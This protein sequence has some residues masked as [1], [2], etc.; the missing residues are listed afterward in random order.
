M[1]ETR[2]ISRDDKFDEFLNLIHRD[3]LTMVQAALGQAVE[4]ISPYSIHYR[5]NE[6]D[7]TLRVVSAEGQLIPEPRRPPVR[8]VGT[9]RERRRAEAGGE[10][11]R[12]LTTRLTNTLES[13]TDAFFHLGPRLALYIH[14]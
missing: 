4:G 11:T 10:E 7:R 8:M 2:R 5:V 14:Q 12:R 6:Q 3:D 13:I 1:A 9:A